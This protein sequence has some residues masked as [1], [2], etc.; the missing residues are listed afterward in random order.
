MSD[1]SIRAES[2][3]L[4]ADPIAPS[5]SEGEVVMTIVDEARAALQNGASAVLTNVENNKTAR[6]LIPPKTQRLMKQMNRR[7]AAQQ[8]RRVPIVPIAIAVGLS[9]AGTVAGVMLSRYLAAR[10]AYEEAEVTA[11]YTSPEAAPAD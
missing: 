6:R 8:A 4:N 1:V 2:V 9:I 10:K 3:R 7:I 5:H 11:E